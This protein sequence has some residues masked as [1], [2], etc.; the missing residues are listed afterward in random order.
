MSEINFYFGSP[1]IDNVADIHINPEEY[2]DVEYEQMGKNVGAV[3]DYNGDGV[4]DVVV[5]SALSI[6]HLMILAGNE[7]WRVEVKEKSLPLKFD[8]SFKVYPNPY[9]REV[10]VQVDLPLSS[11]IKLTIYDIA[12]R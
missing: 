9:N 1:W 8:L 2:Y 10:Q 11:D 12:G 5:Q 3:G 4:D 7:D 6:G